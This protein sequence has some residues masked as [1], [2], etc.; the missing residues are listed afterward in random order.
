LLTREPYAYSTRRSYGN[1]PRVEPRDG[2][3]VPTVV[4]VDE[5]S[6]SDG[7]IFPIIYRELK[8][9]KVIG[10]PSSGAVIGTWEMQLLDGS[11]MRMPGTGWYK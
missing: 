2:I 5:R 8:L 3:Y 7:E 9:G 4:L 10:Y 11:S 1:L 6:F